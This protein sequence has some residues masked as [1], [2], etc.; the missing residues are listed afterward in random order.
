MVCYACFPVS[1]VLIGRVSWIYSLFLA[2]DA[3]FHLKRKGVSSDKVD[4]GLSRGWSYFVEEK[5]FR[6]HLKEFADLP[7]EVW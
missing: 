7:Q 2:I 1:C 4:P 3:N 6:A 5:A